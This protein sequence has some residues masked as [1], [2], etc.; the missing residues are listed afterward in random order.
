MGNA[1]LELYCIEIGVQL[2]GQMPSDKQLEEETILTT[3]SSLKLDLENM[4]Q[5]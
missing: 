3:L 2:D 5:E 4:C 1:C